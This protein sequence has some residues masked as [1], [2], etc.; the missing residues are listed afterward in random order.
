[1]SRKPAATIEPKRIERRKSRCGVLAAAFLIIVLSMP[2]YQSGFQAF[3]S[4][5]TPGNG[6]PVSVV[7]ST[8]PGAATTGPV[9]QFPS[10]TFGALP[11]SGGSWQYGLQWGPSTSY[12][13]AIF[14]VTYFYTSQTGNP[15]F[16]YW[17]AITDNTKDC[18]SPAN[19][20]GCFYQAGLTWFPSGCDS[21]V[22]WAVDNYNGQTVSVG[23]TCPL[24]SNEF[25]AREFTSATESV[26]IFVYQGQWYYA[27]KGSVLSNAP[28]GAQKFPGG[29]SSATGVSG[30]A[31]GVFEGGGGL[32]YA[33]IGEANGIKPLYITSV[34]LS[35][36]TFHLSATL[37]SSGKFYDTSSP[38]P[39]SN[40]NWAVTATCSYT[41]EQYFA[42]GGNPLP[43]SG[44]SVSIC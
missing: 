37:P 28:A 4:E 2:L 39:P 5:P 29:A 22:G 11:P 10:P 12:V 35:G 33:A 14:N 21:Y 40:A 3:G 41:Y 25:A 44:S 31:G 36:G 7:V 9:S 24:P 26:D 30:L 13:G 32:T 38:A 15:S 1:M 43:M 8:T 42:N 19:S 18:G 16:S 6:T 34:T 27:W 20:T 17:L 23:D